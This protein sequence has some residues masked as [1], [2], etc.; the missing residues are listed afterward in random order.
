MCRFCVICFSVSLLLARS[1]PVFAA[2][3]PSTAD[4][5][6]QIAALDTLDEM[7]LTTPQIQSLQ[8]LATD[9]GDD[10]TSTDSSGPAEDVAYHQALIA[11]RDALVSS[12]ATKT[13]AAQ[14]KINKLRESEKIVPDMK[15]DLTEE[16]KKK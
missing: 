2:A 12:D 11:L 10:S 5:E 4:L 16:A 14:Q 3:R 15:I 9:T 8:D 6:L 1:S 7:D 13:Y